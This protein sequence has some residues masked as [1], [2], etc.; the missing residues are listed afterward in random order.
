MVIQMNSYVISQDSK[1][2]QTFHA[3]GR[4]I[5][6]RLSLLA[7]MG[8]SCFLLLRP[9]LNLIF[10]GMIIAIGI[11]PAY[12]ILAKALGG[13]TKLSA[14][15]CSLLLLL[16]ILIP[17]ILLGGTVAGGIQTVKQQVQTG[18]L[19]LPPPPASLTKIPFAGNRLKE[20]WLL[21][22]TNV[23]EAAALLAP[24]VQKKLPALLAASAG[25]GSAILQ[26]L[27]AIVLA[28]FLLATSEGNEKFA[29]RL[30]FRIFNNRGPEFKDLVASTVRTVTNGILG[31][32]VIQAVFASLG[33]WFAGL[34]GAGLWAVIVLV[35]AIL[36]VGALALVP[37]ALYGFAIFPTT[38]A[39]IFLVWCIIVGL[40]DNI[41]KPILLGRGAKV[42]MLVIFLGVLGGFIVM[43]SILGLFLGAIVL[44]VGYKLFM[45]WLDSEAP[46]ATDVYAD[47]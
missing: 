40:M 31:V 1:A 2:D 28:G 6:I 45:A 44:S 17:C 9:F 37:A 19:D 33:F 3:R 29:D 25:I 11:Y 39:V 20:L 7:M 15:L 32:A 13:R 47:H 43:N 14:T 12:R 38:R 21:C 24:Q 46:P 27:V 41:L 35:A 18:R 5:F 23:S 8:V 34:P 22:S 4:E 26:F 30:F 36:Q 16:V 10:C 42:P